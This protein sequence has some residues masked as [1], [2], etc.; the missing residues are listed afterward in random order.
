MSLI[1]KYMEM[2]KS[3]YDCQFCMEKEADFDS[4]AWYGNMCIAMDRK[5]DDDRAVDYYEDEDGE[6]IDFD[7]KSGRNPDC[8]LRERRGNK[9]EEE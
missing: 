6:R 4:S 2:P 5:W 3:C 8:P 7:I 1:I 9:E